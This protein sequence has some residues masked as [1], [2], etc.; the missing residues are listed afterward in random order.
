M[1][2]ISTP[3]TVADSTVVQ[4]AAHRVWTVTRLHFANG[5]TMIALPWMIIGFVFL[6]NMIIWI[7]IFFSTGESLEGTEWSGA[8]AYIYVYFAVA[9]V[10]AMNLT[11]RFALGMSATRRDYYFGTVVAFA[12]QGLL[13][14]A[15]ATLLSYVE[16][17]TNGYGMNAH[18]F[19][20]VYFGTGPLWERLFAG[21]AAFM[22]CFALG[23]L[24]G[25]VFVRWRANGLYA[26]GAIVVLLVVAGV[27]AATLTDSW[28]TVG[29]WFLQVKAIGVVAWLLIPGVVAAVVG[30]YVLR[31]APAR[32]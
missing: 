13:F 21:F 6:I 25:S 17:W 16:D 14:T 9:A 26:L 1:T 8:T 24:A 15:V 18:M 7:S 22:I 10:Q 30:F 4:G 12:L 3:A 11:F 20:N 23:A 5:F 2:A 19:S 27:A 29:A 32:E 31:K 28:A